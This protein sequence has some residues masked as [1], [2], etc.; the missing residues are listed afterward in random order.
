V[1]H[2]H[3]TT[4]NAPAPPAA[5]PAGPATAQ[6]AVADHHT[7]IWRYLRMLGASA[8]EAD[9]L[10]QETLLV[11]LGPGLPAEPAQAR[12][13]LRGV[14]KNQWLRTRR[15][16]QRRR[17]RE[18]AAA[19]DELWLATAEPDDGAELL[20]RLQHCLGTLTPRAQQALDLHYRD[21]LPWQRVAQQLGMK[22]NGTKTLV[23]RARQ[24]L[25]DCLDRRTT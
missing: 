9:E 5:R 8:D 18:V 22:P 25:R 11:A 20:Q 14:A 21:R 12:A 13:F 3:P 10:C 2:P 19:V 16:W 1:P 6:P 24:A 15:F 23:Q 4:T 7:A 17:E